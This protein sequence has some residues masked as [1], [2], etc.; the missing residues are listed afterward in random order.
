[1]IFS[2]ITAVHVNI[3]RIIWPR[4]HKQLMEYLDFFRLSTQ[5]FVNICN[6]QL[7]YEGYDHIEALN[8]L[9]YLIEEG[10]MNFG[11]LTGEIGC[12]K[13]MT[14]QMLKDRLDSNNFEV[15][16]FDN[17][18]VS[19]YHLLIDIVHRLGSDKT[20]EQ[21]GQ[22][23][24]YFLTK[25]FNELLNHK[26]KGLDKSLV[27]ILD[28]AQQ[29]S[30]EDLIELKNLTNIGGDSEGRLTIILVGQPELRSKVK[31]LAQIDQRISLRFHL[32]S[33][34]ATD[35][36]GYVATRLNKSGH[37]TGEIFSDDSLDF[38]A[39][40][41]NGIPRE[42][43]RVCK[44]SMDFAFSQNVDTINK[45]IVKAVVLDLHRQQGKA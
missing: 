43:N 14:R 32:N 42:I 27:L 6:T 2:L 26:I 4:K 20:F 45:D 22:Q 15:I 31:K 37:P 38:L 34:S 36:K 17:S 18:N 23:S 25:E 3:S 8:R 30:D 10:S 39:N 12:G 29:L 44:L 13:T 5:P 16:D 1:M 9:I 33:L 28:E 40:A 35:V 11:M 7:Y 41:T 24:L 21:E 19:F